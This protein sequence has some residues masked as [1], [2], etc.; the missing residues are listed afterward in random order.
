MYF[1]FLLLA[2]L[3]AVDAI[4]WKREK[5]RFKLIPQINEDLASF[6]D[7]TLVRYWIFYCCWHVNKL[8]IAADKK[9]TAHYQL[10]ND[11]GIC[12]NIYHQG[13]SKSTIL[14]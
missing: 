9:V 5:R 6:C 2:I 11:P 1:N 14:N 13:A 8:L 4:L 7:I 3:S 10:V 12:Y